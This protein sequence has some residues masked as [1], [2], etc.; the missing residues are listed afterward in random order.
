MPRRRRSPSPAL[1]LALAGMAVIALAVL[2]RPS[3]ARAPGPLIG[4]LVIAMLV[5]LD[6]LTHRTGVAP[7]RAVVSGTLT[8]GRRRRR[9]RAARR[10]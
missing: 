9:V 3:L 8:V 6:A 2:S 4:T 5:G 1:I 10:S 7:P